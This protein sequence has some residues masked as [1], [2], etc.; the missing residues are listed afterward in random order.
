MYG[1][2]LHYF[3][4][5]EL[6]NLLYE[7]LMTTIMMFLHNH[8]INIMLVCLYN[9]VSIHLYT[10]YLIM[11]DVVTGQFIWTLTQTLCAV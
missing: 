6:M 11:V 2:V 10:N 9:Y 5:Y 8:S 3:D 7:V 4:T 1:E